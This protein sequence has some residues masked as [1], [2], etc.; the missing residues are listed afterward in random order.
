MKLLL[1]IQ[2][3][4]YL[5]LSKLLPLFIKPSPKE[6]SI[7]YLAAF[8]P[9]NA[10]YHWRAKKW[11]E[12][13]N[14]NGYNVTLLHALEEHEFRDYNNNPALFMFRFLHRRFWQ[15][16]KARKYETVIVRREI[17]IYNDYGNLFLEKLLT[18][19]CSKRIL[20]FDDDLAAAKKQP[21][22]ITSPYAKLMLE[23]GNSFIESLQYY[24]KF[25]VA[26]QYLKEYVQKYT[27]IPVKNIAIIPTCVDYDQY[28]A[29]DYSKRSEVFTFGWIGGDHNYPLLRNIIPIL[30]ELANR[31]PFQL[32]V[33][34]GNPFQADAHFPIL[35]KKWSLETEVQDLYNIDV[36][37]MPLKDDDRSKGKGGFKLIQYM[38]LGIVS[39]AS[40][41]TINKEIVDDKVNSFLVYSDEEWEDVFKEILSNNVDLQKMGSKAYE[42][43]KKR[44][45]FSGNKAK[46][47]D[48]IKL[49]D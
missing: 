36:G 6:N 12:K 4:F 9:G 16:I 21:K 43:V 13:L 24:T 35:N 22:A 37:L 44:Y 45:T 25:S 30:N 26:S 47:I 40:A 34:G 10:G 49:N 39:V 18:K 15:V 42:K 20:D 19:L 38:G 3:Y 41:V 1:P 17:L 7:L 8:Y 29:K 28:P 2:L 14:D 46:Y 27:S 11:E 48:F 31:Y 32:L 33:I 23:N 5:A